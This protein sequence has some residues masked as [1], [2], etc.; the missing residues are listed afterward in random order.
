MTCN[1]YFHKVLNLSKKKRSPETSKIFSLRINII[2]KWMLANDYQD[3]VHL[4]PY[5]TLTDGEGG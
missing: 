4:P 2:G 5:F 3:G 1:Q